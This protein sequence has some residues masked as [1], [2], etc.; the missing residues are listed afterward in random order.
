MASAK[1]MFKTKAIKPS[2]LLMQLLMHKQNHLI[3]VTPQKPGNAQ[4]LD[5]EEAWKR[6]THRKLQPRG[7]D[8]VH[9]RS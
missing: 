8:Y 2:G 4:M 5:Y 6:K 7:F 9:M 3:L 1:G